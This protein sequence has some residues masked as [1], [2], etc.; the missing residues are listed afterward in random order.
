MNVCKCMSELG[1][2]YGYEQFIFYIQNARVELYYLLHWFY[3]F[4]SNSYTFKKG[5]C[6]SLSDAQWNFWMRLFCTVK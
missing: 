5:T 2:L 4:V 3:T 1:S 6:F